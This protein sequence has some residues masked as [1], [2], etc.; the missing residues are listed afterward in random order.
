MSPEDIFDFEP[1]RGAGYWSTGSPR[2]RAS[3]GIL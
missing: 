3:S 2:N 1:A